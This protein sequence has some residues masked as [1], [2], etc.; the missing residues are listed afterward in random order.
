MTAVPNQQP[1][2]WRS[3]RPVLAFTVTA[4]AVLATLVLLL[5]VSVLPALIGWQSTVV[6]SGSMRPELV[7]GDVAV[8]RP[9]PAAE[10]EPGQVLLVDDPDA[11][12]ELRL[13]RLIAV[14]DGG[15]RLRGDANATADGSLV[16]PAAVHGVGTVRL[17]A[18]GLPAV[19]ADSGRAAPLAGTAAALAVLIALAL[20]HRREDDRPRSARRA[21]A[22]VAVLLAAVALP[23]ASARFTSSTSTP[24]VTIPMAKWWNCPDVSL[25]TGANAARFYDLQESRGRTA[26][27]TGSAGRSADGTFS[28]GG[29]TYRVAGPACGDDFD[30]AVSFDGSTGAMWTT[31]AVPG[32]QTFSV[33]AWFRTS[34]WNGGKLIGF[35]NGTA[36]AASGQYDRHVYMTNAGKLIFG[37]YNGNY[38]TVTTPGSYNDNR[39]HLVTATF[40][41]GTGMRLYVDRTHI[42][43]TWASSAENT[44]GYW[45]I[46]YDTISGAWPDQPANGWFAGAMAHVGIFDSVLGQGQVAQQ[47][48]MGT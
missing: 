14:E 33:Q 23:G 31:Q 9:V 7:P 18:I 8:V 39:W 19:W 12:G 29:V 44:T 3:S 16:D 34:T 46:G 38:H 24:G 17:P 22:L 5:L 32:P 15:L 6:L 28:A 42:G 36:G 35:G 43:T 48:A 25:S 21:T 47:Y 1:V 4:R 13:H 27:N 41:P 45:R 40:S 11:P 37:I 10:L 2:H 26:D 30:R 20:L